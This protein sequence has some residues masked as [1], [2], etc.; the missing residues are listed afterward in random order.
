MRSGKKNC[1]KACIICKATGRKQQYGEEKE[2]QERDHM[3]K[4][5]KREE[6]SSEK[7][8]AGKCGCREVQEK[9]VNT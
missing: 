7:M 3:R 5:E 9:E 2:K 8:T 1:Q 6:V 4:S